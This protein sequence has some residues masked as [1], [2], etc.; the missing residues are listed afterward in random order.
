MSHLTARRLGGHGR[1]PLPPCFDAFAECLR[2]PANPARW[3]EGRWPRG[4]AGSVQS[5]DPA[6]GSAYLAALPD[7]ATI[8]RPAVPAG[9]TAARIPSRLYTPAEGC[10]VTGFGIVCDFISGRGRGRPGPPGS[11]GWPAARPR[12]PR[13]PPGRRACRLVLAPPTPRTGERLRSAAAGPVRRRARRVPEP[14]AN[15]GQAKNFFA[16]VVPASRV[17]TN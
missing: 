15:C 8:P 3:R 5:G 6:G 17:Q 11:A 7:P 16:G 2:T 14:A 1:Y 4:R 9:R 10:Q 12:P 13:A